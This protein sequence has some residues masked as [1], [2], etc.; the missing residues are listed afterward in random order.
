MVF[1]GYDKQ[2]KEEVAIKLEKQVTGEPSSTEHEAEVLSLISSVKGVPR[3]CW[4]GKD[5]DHN[6]LVT[7]L[8]GRDLSYYIKIVKKFSLK[9]VIQLA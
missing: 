8:L 6:V 1:L 5:A 9:T 7:Q 2:A 3:I 4:Q